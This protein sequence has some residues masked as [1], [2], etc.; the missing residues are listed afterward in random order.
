MCVCMWQCVCVGR[1]E[2][3][4]VIRIIRANQLFITCIISLR[5]I[6]SLYAGGAGVELNQI[7]DLA[8]SR[9]CSRAS[10]AA[11]GWCQQTGKG[12]GCPPEMEREWRGVTGEGNRVLKEGESAVWEGGKPGQCGLGRG[13]G[14]VPAACLR[15][16][17]WGTSPGSCS[18][19]R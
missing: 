5:P 7:G 4:L 19:L 12:R 13:Q 3:C 9:G 14:P 11:D 8:T 2:V 15:G 18:S 10:S 1:C 6:G 16:E 17:V